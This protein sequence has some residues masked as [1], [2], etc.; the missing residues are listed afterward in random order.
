M[1]FPANYKVLFTKQ[2]ALNEKHR[3]LI[4]GKMEKSLNIQLLLVQ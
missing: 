3:K 1:A 2:K 4:K